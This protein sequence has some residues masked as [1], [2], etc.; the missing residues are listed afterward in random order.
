MAADGTHCV[1]LLLRLGIVN[2]C[3]YGFV[4]FLDCAG[5]VSALLEYIVIVDV[6]FIEMEEF[7]CCD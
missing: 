5:Y 2:V 6:Y 3:C 4:T 1:F 7:L